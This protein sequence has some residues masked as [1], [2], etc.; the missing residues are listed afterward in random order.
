MRRALAGAVLEAVGAD[1]VEQ[2][3]APVHRQAEDGVEAVLGAGEVARLAAPVDGDDLALG[4]AADEEALART[5]PGDAFGH[6]AR[7]GEAKRHRRVGGARL[8]GGQALAHRLEFR[9]APE[10]IEAG[11]RCRHDAQAP[12]EQAAQLGQGGIALAE[13]GVGDRL[14]VGEEAVA[15]DAGREARGCARG[16]RAPRLRPRKA[17]R[18]P[19]TRTARQASGRGATATMRAAEAAEPASSAAPAASQAPARTAASPS[20]RRQGVTVGAMSVH[21]AII[22]CRRD[23]RTRAG[24][25]SSRRASC[26][27][28]RRPA[29]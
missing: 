13:G 15:R 16:W 26:R 8:L 7:I 2:A 19:S 9:V 14:V 5:V 1:G 17:R 25:R 29:S 10:R 23:G 28:P 22:A 20:P 3:A 27:S 11:A 24:P 18:P 12:A 4:D 6:E 21:A